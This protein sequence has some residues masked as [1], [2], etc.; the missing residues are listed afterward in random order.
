MIGVHNTDSVFFTF[1]LEDPKTKQPI[2]G[3]KALDITIQIAQDTAHLC[4][5]FLKPPMDLEDGKTLMPFI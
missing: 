1:N 2:R 3:Q 5:E 4:I